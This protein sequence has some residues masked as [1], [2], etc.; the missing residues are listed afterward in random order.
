VDSGIHAGIVAA[1]PQFYRHFADTSYLGFVR[2][3]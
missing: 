1:D 3:G 2:H